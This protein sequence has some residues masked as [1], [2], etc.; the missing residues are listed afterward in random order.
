MN[1]FNLDITE[2]TAKL[3][4]IPV[5]W[6]ATTSYGSGTSNGPSAIL[7]ASSQLDWF[8]AQLGNV[9]KQG[10]YMREQSSLIQACNAEAKPIAQRVITNLD[11]GLAASPADLDC[12][13]RLSEQVNQEV[14]QQAQTILANKQFLAVV[15]GDHSSPFGALKAIAEQYDHFGILHID[16]HMD[17]RKAYQ[18]FTYSHASIM[19]NVLNRL[20]QVKQLTQVGIRDFCEQEWQFVQSNT[21]RVKV[22]YDA[23]NAQ[24]LLS[25]ETW[26]NICDAI[27][28][29]L[30]EKVW[31]SF[32]ID[33][34][35]PRFCPNTGTP[36]PGGL[37]FHQ[38]NFL[39]QQLFASKRE[40]IGFDL[41]EVAPDTQA[42]NEWDANVGMRL[43]YKLSGWLLAS[44]KCYSP[45]LLKI[46]E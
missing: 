31:V 36:V 19:H 37:D 33:G 22:F 44:Q 2:N 8:D 39:L 46:T 29:S 10:L 38:A 30:P 13:N 15:G 32:D 6:E 40:I 26:L 28:A 11:K 20:P 14:Y 45:T 4:Y 18:G 7:K 17:C 42:H 43:L 12:V 3:V 41:C 9:S 24:R 23:D 27:I 34:L 16:A 5:P 35:D 1:I 21:D 25:G